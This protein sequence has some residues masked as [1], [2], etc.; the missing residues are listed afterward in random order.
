LP[1]KLPVKSLVEGSFLAAITALLFIFSIYIPL[2]GTLI[3]FLCPLPIIFL[4]LRHHLKFTLLSL[5]V[6]GFLVSMIAGPLQGIFVLLGFGVIG[7]TLGYTIKRGYTFNEIIIFGSISSLLSKLLILWL[8]FWLMD[9]NPLMFDMQQLDTIIDQSL[10]FYQGLGLSPEQLTILKDN[11]TQTLNI[12]RLAFPAMLILASIFDVFLNYLVSRIV[13]KR[14]GYKLPEFISFSYW[15]ASPSCVLSY[16]VGWILIFLGVRYNLPLLHKIGINVQIFF[17]I[18]FFIIGLSLIN[19]FLQKYKI[20][21]IFKWMIY[22]LIF[23]LPFL[24]QFITWVGI[25]DVWID[26]RRLRE[27]RAK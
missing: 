27:T 2:L 12:F 5:L 25:F 10:N 17:T 1:E 14:F 21:S 18:L 16:L 26:F 7:L 8:G 11:L 3:S 19:F 13:L 20:G 23:F 24:S 15:R 22:F 6:A 9:L 4:Y